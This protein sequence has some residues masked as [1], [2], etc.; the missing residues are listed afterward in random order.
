MFKQWISTDRSVLETIVKPSD[1]FS[2]IQG[3]SEK[4]GAVFGVNSPAQK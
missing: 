3:V 4:V 2:N 1:E